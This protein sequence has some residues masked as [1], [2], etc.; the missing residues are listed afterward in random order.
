MGGITTRCAGGHGV[1]KARVDPI[2]L[3]GRR[4]QKGSQGCL[5]LPRGDH[6]DI[7]DVGNLA[8]QRL[9]G[10]G[11]LGCGQQG[12][13]GRGRGR[14]RRDTASGVGAGCGPGVVPPQAASATVETN[15]DDND[16]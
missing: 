12:A 6:K 16:P 3:L 4:L 2:Q 7:R 8:L 14:R 15:K 10:R 1:G 13:G 5:G 11:H 9:L